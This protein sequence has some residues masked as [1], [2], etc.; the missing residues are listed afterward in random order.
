ML[1]RLGLLAT[2]IALVAP[3]TAGATPNPDRIFHLSRANGLQLMTAY[4]TLLVE[5]DEDALGEL[6]S[7]AFQIQ[8]ADGSH[9]DRDEYLAKLPDLRAFSFADVSTRRGGGVLTV[10]MTALATL[11][12]NGAMYSPK[13]APQMGVFQWDGTRWLL[14][15]QGNFNLPRP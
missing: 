1:R 14:V 9:Q 11:F 8:R 5:K 12:V 3:A 15:G 7:P 6:L 2:V 13:P 10:R 4:S